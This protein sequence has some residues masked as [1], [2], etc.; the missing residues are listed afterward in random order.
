M[1]SGIGGRFDCTNVVE[2]PRVCG[3]TSLGLDHQ[4]MLGNT[5]NEIAFH[6]C[7]I[8]K[9]GAKVFVTRP[10]EASVREVFLKEANEKKVDNLC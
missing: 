7:G 3:I 1:E 5:L 6:K 9:P 8:I 2:N 4:S 10:C